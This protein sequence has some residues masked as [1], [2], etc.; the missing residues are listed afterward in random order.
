MRHRGARIVGLATLVVLV[1]A[2]AAFART[3]GAPC[4]RACALWFELGV[5]ELRFSPGAIQAM[6]EPADGSAPQSI[7]PVPGDDRAVTAQVV[8]AR[9][10]SSFAD[11]PLY[12][13]VELELGRVTAAPQL[14]ATP[15]P[16]RGFLVSTT[17]GLA[18]G[19]SLALG[20]HWLRGSVSF[21]GEFALGVRAAAL[22]DSG[23]PLLVAKVIEPLLEARAKADLWLTPTA[24]LG[25]AVG[26]DTIDPRDVS[27]AIVLGAHVRDYD[28][29]RA[30]SA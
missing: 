1:I 16:T 25:V 18:F 8:R 22:A 9:A 26:V 29:M 4:A 15:D 23:N 6:T 14:M 12:T 13:A 3:R 10:M 7:T 30:P 21:G 11:T 5:G 27:F 24:S 19:T 17:G 20:A 2:P 28:R